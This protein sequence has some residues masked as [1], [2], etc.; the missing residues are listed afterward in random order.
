VADPG[1]L[2][3]LRLGQGGIRAD[4]ADRR[5]QARA[6]A[7]LGLGDRLRASQGVLELGGVRHSHPLEL[8]TQAEPRRIQLTGPRVDRRAGGVHRDERG[9]RR[10][11][12]QDGAGRADGALDA[13]R[14]GPRGRADAAL[15]HGTV[16]GRRIRRRALVGP[17]EPLVVSAAVE[18]EEHGARDYRRHLPRGAE[19][20]AQAV[21]EQR[22]DDAVRR[23]E[24]E[25]AAA[26]EHDG[27]D[28]VD[29]VPGVEEVG[30]A[31]TGAATADVHPA[32]RPA[33][34]RED[35]RGAGQPARLATRRMT[36]A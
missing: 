26:A 36:D 27:V 12:R 33:G 22:P 8:G 21:G 32:G 19:R 4:D 9:H 7:A 16:V 30:L 20:P 24:P 13:A 5:R 31:G 15:L 34:R 28:P 10:A 2:L 1:D 29:E 11:V 25:H 17:G 14:R 6:P 35:H 18:V 3:A 23:R